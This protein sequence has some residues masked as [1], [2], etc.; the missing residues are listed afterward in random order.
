VPTGTSLVILTNAG[1]SGAP[2]TNGSGVYSTPNIIIS[3]NTAAAGLLVMN[4]NLFG[5]MYHTILISNGVTLALSNTVSTGVAQQ[6]IIQV[7]SQSGAGSPSGIGSDYGNNAVI[8]CTIEGAGGTLTV[9][10]T[11]GVGSTF[12]RG[13][14]FAG[15]GTLGLSA[16]PAID[17]MNAILDLSGLDTFVA[18]AN[19]IVLGDGGAAPF[20]FNRPAGTIYF[21][22]TNIIRLAAV[23]GHASASQV[24]GGFV[25]GIMAQNNGG[26]T[27]RLGRF[28]LG[29][30]NSI[31]CNTGLEL[32]IRGFSGWL[33]FNPSN[34]PGTSAALF[35]DRATGTGRQATWG[36]ADR[37]NAGILGDVSGELDFSR[38]TVDALVGILGIAV[39]VTGAGKSIGSVEFGA[40]TI[41]VNTLYLGVQSNSI[42]GQVQGIL[43]VS[44]TATLRVNT[45]GVFG[46]S[47]GNPGSTFFARLNI[48]DGG[49]ALFANTAPI[50]CG[51]GSSS[52]IKVLGGSQLSVLSIG[53][54]AA[55]LT[56][57]QISNSTLTIDRGI[58]SN[59][60]QPPVAVSSLDASGVN[61]VNVLGTVLVQGRFPLIQYAN[62]ANGG[63]SNF[64][65]GATSPGVAGYLTNNVA[66][67]S[68][69]F[70]V[71][72]STTFFLAWNGR[73]NGVD[74]G[75]W[76]IG[77]TPDWQGPAVYAQASVPGSLVQFDDSA[78]G[79]TTVV[80]TNQNLSPAFMFVTNNSK[81]YSFT[82]SG[83]IVG[84]GGLTKDGSG[85]LLVANTGTN[86]FSGSM[87]LNNGILQIGLA[88]DRLP[89]S[90]AL[91][92]QDA[93]GCL[94]DLNNTN[95]ALASI[96]GGGPSGGNISLGSGTLTIR[97]GGGTYGGVISGTG[98]LYKSTT[99][100]ETL[101]GANTYSG[102][103]VISNSSLFVLNNGSG[104]GLGS[105]TVVIGGGGT[106]E[107][108]N[109]S[110]DGSVSTPVITNNGTLILGPA[111]STTLANL[112]V[113]SG[114]L[115]KLIGSG[116]T[117][118]V[119]NANFYAGSSTV[120]QGIL[121]VSDPLA[122]STGVINVGNATLTDTELAVAGGI[123][124]TNPITL[125]G[126]TGAI[127]PSAVGLNNVLDVNSGLP[128]TNTVL[129]SI[130]LLGSTC[131][132]VGSDAGKLVI[133]GPLI[134]S[135]TAAGAGAAF[136]IR[137]DGDGEF[138]SAFSQGAGV[139]LNLEKD[140]NGTWTFSNTNTYTGYTI[141]N[142]GKVVVNGAI[143]GSSRV[144]V[145]GSAALAGSGKITA[146]VTND[147]NLFP[148]NDS[149]MG[150]LT[151]SN[152]LT[153]ESG[154]YGTF[155][156]SSNGND[157]V[158]GLTQ[159]TYAGTLR[160][161]LNGTLT[162]S[163]I[164][165]L[166]DAT[167]YTGA[168]DSYD[169][170][171]IVPMGL[172][173][174]TSYLAVDGTLHA[175]NGV[176]VTPVVTSSGFSGGSFRLSGTG[177][178]VA[179]YSITAT[180]NLTLPFSSWSNIGSGTFSNGVFNFVDSTATNFPIRFYRLVTPT[181]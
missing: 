35:R 144:K 88:A 167:N 121:Q 59:P 56:S 89:T 99:G 113:G 62:L 107:L 110:L 175:T 27:T 174:D 29:L 126:K 136:F 31:Y 97:G 44:N 103:T 104:S 166:F 94:L 39:N 115:I 64:V 179:P 137:G 133:A 48:T 40:G 109:C 92:I 61:V 52:E 36:V 25:T 11:N 101:L 139:P 129:G 15:Q 91:T 161:V 122:L 57:L 6:N 28:F 43:S 180:T 53:T 135:S 24:T 155:D 141:I 151:I 12:T 173:W 67:S 114:N 41:D 116:S 68:I 32:G 69:D 60:N 165:K 21:A 10:S 73:T 152:S 46:G 143:I 50:I 95:Q 181:P 120:Q 37:M 47:V 23:G 171:N 75:N 84:P 168:F 130:T 7:C 77:L 70:V 140:E 148:G 146:A 153:F 55:P 34:A 3:N 93:A 125:S 8:T 150:T 19:H 13:N 132:A 58:L 65:L 145:G 138:R 156:V 85:T 49:K 54:L 9:N 4:T 30:T 163:C 98:G 71:T 2:G 86:T 79:T 127:V 158:R 90:A 33:G 22:K 159:V 142:G 66:N 172:D 162:G 178:L 63:F 169:L 149:V 81:N 96:T 72:S 17:P 5:A 45:L 128:T 119:T 38:G 134:N 80:I 83:S 176:V 111:S 76:D 118:Y 78:A 170:P 131:F 18:D 123:S 100:T 157:Q 147:G 117:L 87:A 74:T 108:G 82:G 16:A 14:I 164:F 26:G 112:V 20:F 105:G 154:S 106:L 160:V 51:P 1:I 124:L 102:G 42:S 177:T